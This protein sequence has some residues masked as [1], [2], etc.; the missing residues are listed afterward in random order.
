MYQAGQGPQQDR[1]RKR[2]R[3]IFWLILLLIVAVLIVVAII[4]IRDKLKSKPVIKQ[5]AA[6]TT[7]VSYNT[8]TKLYNEP[9]FSI[10]LPASWQPE[11]RPPGPFQSYTWHTSANGTDGQDLVVYEDS[12]PANLSVNRVLIVQ[13]ENDRLQVNGQVSDNCANFTK[14]VS[15]NP[16]AVGAA[17][18]WQG[19]D[20]HCDQTNTERDVVGTSSTDGINI[21]ILK[22]QLN[23]ADHK[24][25]FTFTDNS[26]NPD[27]SVFY[28]ALTSLR[29][30]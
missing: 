27:Y 10:S 29:M 9:D 20:F 18:K 2:R 6:I 8:Q 5:A 19:V 24:F 30:N 21:V 14:N 11:P 26:V 23:G 16:L 17:A 12:L 28:N 25:F 1:K 7:Q 3:R 4:V 22:S 15:S 13:S